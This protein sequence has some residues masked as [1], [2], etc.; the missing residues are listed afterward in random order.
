MQAGTQL[1]AVVPLDAVYVIANFKETQLTY[2]RNGQPGRVLRQ[3]GRYRLRAR[4]PSASTTR[5]TSSSRQVGLWVYASTEY[6][7]CQEGHFR[8]SCKRAFLKSLSRQETG[9]STASAAA[10]G[11]VQSSE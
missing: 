2:V 9:I 8:R 11:A 10:E 7:E 1:M 6:C 3:V 4:Q 5:F